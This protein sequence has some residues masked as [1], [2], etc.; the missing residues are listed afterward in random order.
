MYDRKNENALETIPILLQQRDWMDGVRKIAIFADF[1]YSINAD[2][3]DGS[4]KVQK[5][6]GVI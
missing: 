2:I 3:V 5:C 6:A 1:Q 4:E